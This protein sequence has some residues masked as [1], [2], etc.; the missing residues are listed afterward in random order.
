[1]PI[2][3]NNNL[4]AL[5][6]QNSLTRATWSMN[7]SMQRLTTGSRINSA[8]D[9]PAGL[10]YAMGL[11]TQLRGTKVAQQ[12]IAAG[13]SMLS[14]AEG[15]LTIIND[16]LERIKD[17][18]TQYSNESLSEE[19]QKALKEE[20][21]QRIEEIDRI[22]KDSKFNKVN[23]LDGSKD[24]MR[25]QIGGGSDPSTNAIHVNG[26]F[27]DAT[28]GQSG[29]KLFGGEYADVEAAFINA[30]TAGKFVSVVEA[31]A[32]DVTERISRA[33]IYQNR[34][35]SISNLLLTQTENLTSA[36]SAIFDTDIA[37]ETANYVKNQILQQTA[38][39]MLTQA[40]QSPGVLA[41]KLIAA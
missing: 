7:T 38:S 39:A 12:N 24:G 16:H 40:N 2:V 21:Q 36:Y 4:P 14:N 27:K 9:D 31:A 19:E 30:S 23:L 26:V 25:L 11:N 15:D 37:A 32:T 5:R 18:A 13:A 33:G 41:L 1:M 8:K 3:I 6:A 28:T 34:L 10:Y 17:L 35:D 22:S 29:L 20:V